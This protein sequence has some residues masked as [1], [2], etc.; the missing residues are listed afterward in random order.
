[1]VHGVDPCL[2][3]RPVRQAE[4]RQDA[5]VEAGI[6]FQTV[7]ICPVPDWNLYQFDSDLRF[8]RRDKC[9]ESPSRVIERPGN[10]C[11]SARNG[12]PAETFIAF[13]GTECTVCGDQDSFFFS[14]APPMIKFHFDAGKNSFFYE[15]ELSKILKH[16]VVF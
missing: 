6:S 5:I 15:F 12:I 1:M 4:I 13:A 3:S 9:R 16:P 11:D 2:N 7:D 10:R 14:F 8:P